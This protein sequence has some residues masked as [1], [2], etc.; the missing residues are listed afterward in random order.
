MEKIIIV[1]YIYSV[2]TCYILVTK[3]AVIHTRTQAE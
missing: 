3:Y 1:V 2:K